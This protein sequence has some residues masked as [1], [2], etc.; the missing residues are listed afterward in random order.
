[1]F[2]NVFIFAVFLWRTKGMSE[3]GILNFKYLIDP[4]LSFYEM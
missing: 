1:M 3:P 2:K 4:E